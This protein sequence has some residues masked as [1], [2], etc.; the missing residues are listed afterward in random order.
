MATASV[1]G[2]RK[3]SPLLYT[4]G[5]YQAYIVVMILAV[6]M[7]TATAKEGEKGVAKLIKGYFAQGFRIT[8]FVKVV[9]SVT[10]GREYR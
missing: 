4:Q 8:V 6:I 10:R 5:G 7:Q 1:H 3:G 2:D 9:T